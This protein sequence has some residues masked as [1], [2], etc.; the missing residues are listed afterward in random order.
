MLATPFSLSTQKGISWKGET[1]SSPFSTREYNHAQKA[2][3]RVRKRAQQEFEFKRLIKI[4]SR[5]LTTH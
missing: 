3:L 5:A 1:K 4:A 2:S